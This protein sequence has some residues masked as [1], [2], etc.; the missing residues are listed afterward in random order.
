MDITLKK[1]ESAIIIGQDK[2]GI[3]NAVYRSED[4]DSEFSLSNPIATAIV[5]KMEEDGFIKSLLD[6]LYDKFEDSQRK[7]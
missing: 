1:N 4:Y 2:K 5:L 6:F 3:Y 7:N